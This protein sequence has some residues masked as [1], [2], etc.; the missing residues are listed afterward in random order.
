MPVSQRQGFRLVDLNQPPTEQD[1]AA[2]S[3]VLKGEVPE[4]YRQ[5]ISQ[6][7]SGTFLRK[8][9]S[10][11]LPDFDNELSCFMGLNAEEPT[12]DILRKKPVL[13]GDRPQAIVVTTTES[14]EVS[15]DATGR[16]C[17]FDR[18][19]LELTEIGPLGAKF[20]AFLASIQTGDIDSEELRFPE[21]ELLSKI[22]LYRDLS[23]RMGELLTYRNRAGYTPLSVAA[24]V[25]YHSL[26]F[27]LLKRGGEIDPRN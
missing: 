9:I 7:N 25:S 16:L 18:Q 21:D 22:E 4:E 26:M 20:S 19:S 13:S 24:V 1:F 2:L 14:I 15:L 5:F 11:W 17:Q 6:M 23:G 10:S 12:L 8:A 3:V 27:E